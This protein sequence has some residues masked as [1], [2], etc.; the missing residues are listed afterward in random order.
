MELFLSQETKSQF[1]SLL[2]RYV[3]PELNKTVVIHRISS[4]THSKLGLTTVPIAVSDGVTITNE[5]EIASTVCNQSRCYSLLVGR[6]KEEVNEMF[7]TYDSLSKS[8]NLM[9]DLNEKLRLQTWLANGRL[10]LTDIKA[11]T[12]VFGKL[13]SISRKERLNYFN[14]LR[15]YSHLQSL[16]NLGTALQE[17]KLWLEIDE[18]EQVP[19]E[20]FS[21]TLAKK[22]KKEVKPKAV[23]EP[24][25]KET[26]KKGEKKEK[27]AEKKEVKKEEPKELE[28]ISKVDVRVGKI[29]YVEANEESEKLYNEKIDIG[30]EVRHIASGLKKLVPIEDLKDRMVVVI[31]NLEAKNLCGWNSHGMLLCVSSPDGKIEPLIPPEGSK[32]GDEVFFG[33][34]PREAALKPPKKNPWSKVSK[35]I[36]TNEKGIAV[37]D[38][39][40]V[41]KT[42]NGECYSSILNGTIS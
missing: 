3:E 36:T 13:S 1:L 10:T 26:D 15:W 30:T 8:S 11:A 5:V 33:D 25:N 22:E 38:G 34:F 39:T 35:M 6:T 41:W 2:T 7:E 27:K 20:L 9:D 31:C 18:N 12:L 42:S 21:A 24:E 37:Y 14:V 4:E 28:A 23:K 17:H 19:F 40:H 16:E 29:I 32:P